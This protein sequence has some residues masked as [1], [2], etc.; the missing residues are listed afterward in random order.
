[1]E[2][3]AT[4]HGEKGT[5]WERSYSGLARHQA[6]PPSAHQAQ[7]REAGKEEKGRLDASVDETCCPLPSPAGADL[8]VRGD[9]CVKLDCLGANT[10]MV[11]GARRKQKRRKEG[12]GPQGASTRA[13]GTCDRIAPGPIFC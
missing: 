4:K 13:R 2:G 6:Y 7:R 9:R 5:C 12:F 8:A 3:S 10:P 1:M 11:R